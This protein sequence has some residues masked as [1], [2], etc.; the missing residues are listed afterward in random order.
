M[1]GAKWIW[2]DT[3]EQA[4]EYV[5]FFDSFDYK[6]G[7]V[8]MEISVVGDYVLYLNGEL[9][10]FGQYPDY[11]KY[12]VYDL[13][14]VTS[15]VHYGK[16]TIKIVCWYIGLD[17]LTGVKMPRGLYYKAYTDEETL[18][19]SLSDVPC[20]VN[21]DYVGY[22]KKII[23][24]Q[25]G[26]SYL[27]DTRYADVPQELS[28]AVEA[29]GFENLIRRQNQ[30]VRLGE[31]VFGKEI[32]KE[33]KIY[34]LG[35]ECCGFLHIKF[36][37]KRGETLRIAYGEH[38]IDGKVRDVIGNRDFSV[39][40][41]GNGKIAEA[42][43]LFR[44][45]GC[46]YLQIYG[47]KSSEILEIG[48]CQAEYPFIVKPYRI[49]NP[50]RKKIY[51]ISLDTLRLCAHEHYEDCPWREQAMYVQDSRNQMLCG[52][53]AFD[54]AEFARASILSM[55]SGQR[56]N[57]LLEMCFPSKI[58]FTIPSFALSF[59]AVVL[60]YTQWT[61]SREIAEKSFEPI[62]KLLR[63]F[64]ENLQENGL[65]K[66]VSERSLWHFYEWSGDLDGN[67]FSEDETKK[68]RNDY[69]VLINAFLS[70]ACGKTA[71]LCGVLGREKEK[72]YYQDVVFK[73]NRAIHTVFFDE[74]RGLYKTYSKGKSYSQLANALCILCGACP[75]N[76]LGALA[77]KVAFGVSDWVQNTLSMN[78]FRFDAL[79]AADKDKYSEFILEEIDR[80]Y[81][82]MLQ[83]GATS[84]WETEKGA[85]DFD[86][87]GSLCH[88][89]SAIP[90]Y[91]YHLLNVVK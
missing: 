25:L 48:I 20:A 50:L 17:C 22:R 62:E 68:E 77:E 55:L 49:D 29:E 53:V 51:E 69:D 21:E 79:L 87:A 1:E 44:R 85:A 88:G 67:Y 91:Y 40:L 15:F 16:N 46:R 43:L 78:V 63:F 36:R 18:A 27:Y 24:T 34:D 83:N 89:W 38:L 81:G 90:V 12:K 64:L 84:F 47:E 57:G 13:L 23:T 61:G 72:I 58:E 33:K 86:G 31:T 19:Q 30:K 54:N 37:A 75:E 14:D 56:D 45:L 32:D 2:A 70:W 66:T 10:A 41:I 74:E 6:E 71:E 39:E 59:P 11:E 4:D 3:P 76:L 28:P 52:Y 8:K 7:A 42:T 82:N 5:T 73:L 65:Y 35:K 80:I 60:E 26:Y 9:V